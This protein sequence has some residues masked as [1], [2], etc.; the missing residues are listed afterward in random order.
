MTLYFAYGSNMDWTQM[1]DR[2]PSAEFACIA[3]LKNHRL[4]FTR[5][6]V[7]RGCG[8]SDALPAERRN[9]WGVVY[10]ISEP[11]LLELDKSEGFDAD[12][13]MER[14]SYNRRT[15]TVCQDGDE[16]KPLS[17]EIYFAMPQDNPPLP[18]QEYKGLILSSAR[19]WHLPTDYIAELERIEVAP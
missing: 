11:D 15:Q 8:V 12:R 1:C 7:N 19:H 5:R 6:S 18:N 4:A 16:T 14:N 10:K 9:V 3:E 2:C 13:P 17:V